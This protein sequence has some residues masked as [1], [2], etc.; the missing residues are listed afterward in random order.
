MS[1]TACAR[2]WDWPEESWK[3]LRLEG[4]PKTGP[5]SSLPFGAALALAV[6]LLGERPF[7]FDGNLV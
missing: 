1:K 3:R 4:F 6:D 2:V 5:V 7:I